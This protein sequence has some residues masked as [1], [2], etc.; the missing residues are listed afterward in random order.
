MTPVKN[1]GEE[2]SAGRET[3]GRDKRFQAKRGG[4]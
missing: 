3:R 4:N 2:K 1:A